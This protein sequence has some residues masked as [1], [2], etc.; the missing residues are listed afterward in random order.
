LV[1]KRKRGG[2]ELAIRILHKAQKHHIKKKLSAAYRHT[3]G[4][5]VSYGRVGTGGEVCKKRGMVGATWGTK[6]RYEQK[7]TIGGKKNRKRKKL[8]KCIP[9]IRQ[10]HPMIDTTRHDNR[11]KGDKHTQGKYHRGKS[12]SEGRG[13]KGSTR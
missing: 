7:P 6:N 11:G 8:Y 5:S 4:F 2:K 1:S 13:C 9:N 3:L 10:T 12:H